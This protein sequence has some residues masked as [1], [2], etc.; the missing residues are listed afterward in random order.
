[1]TSPVLKYKEQ[2]LAIVEQYP[3]ATMIIWTAGFGGWFDAA[4]V[5]EQKSEYNLGTWSNAAIFAFHLLMTATFSFGGAE[6]LGLM[7]GNR[8]ACAPVTHAHN[9]SSHS[10]LPTMPVIIH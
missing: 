10:R 3:D 4:F 8:Q 9:I 1:M 5:E 7:T 6:V 2:L